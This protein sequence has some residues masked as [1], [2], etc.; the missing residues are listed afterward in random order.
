MINCRWTIWITIIATLTILVVYLYRTNKK[1]RK[2]REL[3]I[4]LEAQ[5]REK[6]RLAKDLHDY[7]GARLS[8]LKLYMQTINRYDA[9]RIATMTNAAM[10]MIDS[11]IIELRHLLFDLNPKQ[12]HKGK[13]I[14]ALTELVKNIKDILKT[15]IETDFTEYTHNLPYSSEVSVY[16]IIQELINNT[17][18]HAQATHIMITLKQQK[19]ELHLLYQDNGIG[20]DSESVD[21]GYGIRN[22]QQH[23]F[24]MDGKLQITTN[25]N[26]GF[27]CIITLPLK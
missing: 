26:Q 6:E 21:Y 19:K 25:I 8:T 10:Q 2:K 20:F 3:K 7:F 11:T 23:T 4:T 17:L 24:A 1:K 18:K 9:Q 16:R 22:I 15:N 13:L 5:E 12:L 27:S 14:D